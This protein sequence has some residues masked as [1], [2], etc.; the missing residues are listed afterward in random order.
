MF[1]I[2]VHLNSSYRE[3]QEIECSFT[4]SQTKSCSQHVLATPNPPLVAVV[5]VTSKAVI[6]LLLLG[7]CLLVL[8]LCVGFCVQ[9][10]FCNIVLCGYQ[11][12][13]ERKLVF[14]SGFVFLLLC[15]NGQVSM[16]RKYHN[17]TLQTNPRHRE[18]EPQ[19]NNNHKTPGRQTK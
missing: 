8:Q 7:N 15:L 16:I 19:N 4:V 13:E 3:S 17:N 2:V 9:S 12:S 6:L 1:F 14:K 18:E 11:L 5:A 10:D